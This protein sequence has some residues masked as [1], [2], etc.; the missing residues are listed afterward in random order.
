MTER[1]ST[2]NSFATLGEAANDYRPHVVVKFHDHV[3]FPYDESIG[4]FLDE[5]FLD[6]D[7]F[8]KLIRR[9]F[10]QLEM[11]PLCFSLTEGQIR[12]LVSDATLDTPFKLPDYL[13]YYMAQVPEDGAHEELAKIYSEWKEFVEL[14]YVD[15]PS[16]DPTVTPTALDILLANQA[17]LEPSPQGIDVRAAW[18]VN[19]GGGEGQSFV[20]VEQGWTLDHE[21]FK[22]HGI[23][24]MAGV[25]QDFSHRHGTAVLGIV[26][27]DE[28]VGQCVGIAPHVRSVRVVSHYYGNGLTDRYNAIMVGLAALRRGGVLLIEV[29][30]LDA[31]IGGRILSELP[32][33]VLNAE[34]AAIR[35]ATKRGIV[36]VEAAGN[37]GKNLDA[38]TDD[39]GNPA[40][41]RLDASFEETLAIMVGAPPFVDQSGR[42]LQTNFGNRIDCYAWGSQ[43]VTTDST[44]VAPFATNVYRNDFSG[45]SSAAAI[46]AGVALVV[47]GIQEARHNSH[48]DSRQMRDALVKNGAPPP[49]GAPLIGVMPDLQSIVPLI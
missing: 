43:V 26:C 21:D 11:R 45:S 13:S 10:P 15:P 37:A 40:L 23:T 36:V 42:V 25:N 4:K 35:L 2:P 38:L 27:A 19:G 39:F 9:R 48:L 24:V 8:W 31:V 46:V 33:E 3:G 32:V 14:A 20:D 34:R 6:T 44:N 30:I 5:K 22:S 29:Q 49:A 47:Q 41:N 16:G 12:E 28:G 17:Y 1:T 7:P 18:G